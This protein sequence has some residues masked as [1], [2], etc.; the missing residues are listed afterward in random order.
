M[1]SIHSV[2]DEIVDNRGLG[3]CR[4][5]AQIAEI[6]FRDF[7][8]NTAHDFSGSSF[9]QARRPLQPIWRRDRPNFLSD[10]LHQLFPQFV[11]GF[12]AQ[13]QGD[14]GVNAL[15]LDIM[16]RTDHGSFRYALVRDQGGF[17]LGGTHSVT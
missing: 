5:I 3:E 6:V 17:D 8:Q 7:S 12:L 10:P 2:I 11:R 15:S 9:W 4:S 1:L 14:I 16:R 13:I